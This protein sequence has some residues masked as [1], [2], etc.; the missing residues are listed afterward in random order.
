MA[1]PNIKYNIIAY[2]QFLLASGRPVNFEA[3]NKAPPPTIVKIQ[4]PAKP[5]MTHG[6]YYQKYGPVRYFSKFGIRYLFQNANL[7]INIGAPGAG[8]NPNLTE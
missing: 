3:G 7:P 2:G 5:I 6:Q 1:I 4:S 8:K